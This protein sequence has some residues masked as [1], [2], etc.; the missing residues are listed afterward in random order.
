MCHC[1][2]DLY[3]LRLCSTSTALSN[4]RARMVL[5]GLKKDKR[6]ENFGKGKVATFTN[7]SNGLWAQINDGKWTIVTRIVVSGGIESQETDF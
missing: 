4:Q 2:V 3:D 5:S 7:G 1:W 6:D